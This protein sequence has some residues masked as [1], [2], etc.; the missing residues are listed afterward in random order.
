MDFPGFLKTFIM[1]RIKNDAFNFSGSMGGMTFYK[2]EF[3]PIVKRKSEGPTELTKGTQDGNMEMGGASMAAK[4][5]RQALSSKQR[6]LE[7]HYFSGRLS[8]MMRK[9]VALG[10]GSP[11]ERR[12][13]LRKNGDLLESFEFINER[14][15]VYSVGGIK[16]KPTYS[17]GRNK[18]S[19]I[20]PALKSKTQISPPEGATH[21]KFILGA[22]TVSNYEYN[23]TKKE[24]TPVKLQFKNL[25]DFVESAPIAL[26]VKNIA[27]VDLNVQLTEASPLPEEVAV[28]TVV[29]VSFMKK[30]NGEMLEMKDTGG[31]RVLEVS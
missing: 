14:P 27:P 28:V 1:A 19:W 25:G 13:D 18:I 15:L 6:E 17:K 23:K 29:G 3:G 30:M 11:G 10:E 12:L 26:K 22:G 8:G 24:Y 9:V 20:S 31:M 7:D 5:L 2:D 21:F 4:A 16:E